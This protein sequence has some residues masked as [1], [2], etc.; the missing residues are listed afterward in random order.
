MKANEF[1]I[2]QFI[3]V[4]MKGYKK[5]IGPILLDENKFELKFTL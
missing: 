4:F 3:L 5:C 2:L 1:E